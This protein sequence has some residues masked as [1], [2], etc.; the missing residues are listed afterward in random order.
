[1]HRIDTPTAQLDKFGQGKN[2]FTNGD[3]TTGRRSTDLNSDMWDAIQEEI[4]NAI[5]GNGIALEKSKH[6]Q[7]LLAIR[8]AITDSGFLKKSNDLSDLQDKIISRS[9]LQVYSQ[10]E[11]DNKYAKITG[12]INQ[13]LWVKSAPGDVNSAVPVSLLD[14]GLQKKA[15]LNGDSNVD[16]Y[17]RDN[18][19]ATAAVNNE[20][21]NFVLRNYTSLSQFQ[22]GNNG[23]GSWT[24]IAGGGQWCRQNMNLNSNSNNTWTFPASFPSAPAIFITSFNGAFQCW[25]NGAGPSDCSIYNNGPG[26]NVNVLA[27]W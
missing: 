24:K 1:M 20:R 25:L 7:L 2:G 8:K 22:S 13:K 16:F 17:V 5:E 11:C 3:P 4:A 21:M 18:G 12:D 10:S 6:N 19:D 9:N 15:N 26:L 23:N 14:S 27:I